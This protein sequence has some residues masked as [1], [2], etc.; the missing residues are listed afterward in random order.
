LPLRQDSLVLQTD[1]LL[2]Q[3]VFV[4]DAVSFLL[5]FLKPLPLYHAKK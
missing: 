3:A 2:R 5:L 4:S 1:G